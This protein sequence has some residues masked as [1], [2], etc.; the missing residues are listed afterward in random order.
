VRSQLILDA[1]EIFRQVAWVLRRL[2]DTDSRRKER[3]AVNATDEDVWGPLVAQR[4]RS[5]K[6]GRSLR[7]TTSSWS[8]ILRPGC[9]TADRLLPPS[10]TPDREVDRGGRAGPWG[11]DDERIHPV[12][13]DV[14]A[15]VP[16]A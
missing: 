13:L 6:P 5:R 10:Q 15:V 2:L 9:L 12:V 4:L 8:P 7:M 16:Q 3:R 1:R 11:A 14:R